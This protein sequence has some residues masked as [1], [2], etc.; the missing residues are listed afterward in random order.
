MALNIFDRFKYINT[1]IY[2]TKYKLCHLWPWELLRLV[3]ECCEHG[4]VKS[5]IPSLL[6]GVTRL[7]FLCPRPE[8]SPSPKKP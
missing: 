1:I 3:P 5:L 7:I 6:S 2:P 4:P 8:T